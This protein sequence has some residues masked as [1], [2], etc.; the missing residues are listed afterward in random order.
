M[1]T[2]LDTITSHS[3]W[4]HRSILDTDKNEWNELR[5][6]AMRKWAEVLIYHKQTESI[7]SNQ[8]FLIEFNQKVND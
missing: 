4:L 6:Q 2:A 7:G 1:K 5:R 8:I 3:D